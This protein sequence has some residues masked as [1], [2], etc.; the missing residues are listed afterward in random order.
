[1]ANLITDKQK[2]V[3]QQ[4]YVIRLVTVCL[5]ILSL[6]GLFVLAYIGPYY[7]SVTKNDLIISEQLQTVI[8]TENKE[9]IGQS[10]SRLV[11]RTLDEVK[12]VEIYTQEPITPSKDF[13][14]IIESKNSDIQINRLSFRI[15]GDNQT[16][17]IVNGISKT[18][19]GLIRFVDDLKKKDGFAEVESPISGFAKESD[20]TFTVT[21]MV[22]I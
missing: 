3:L 5:L 14:K 9:N 12:A 6:F 16:Q 2:K 19:D 22:S 18:R 8:N 11:S 17:Y 1:M 13:T 20:I 7:L 10:V 4:E 15:T 21:I